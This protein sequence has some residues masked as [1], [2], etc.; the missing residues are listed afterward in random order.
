MLYTTP[1]RSSMIR[2]S[3]LIAA[4]V[5]ALVSTSAAS[6]TRRHDPRMDDID[7]LLEKAYLLLQVTEC[8]TTGKALKDCE[9]SLGKALAGV[10]AVR[11]HLADA[12]AAADAGGQ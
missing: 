7:A 12:M 1:L 9:R 10:E 3:M 8:G 4:F 11:S 6:G 5:S 2:R